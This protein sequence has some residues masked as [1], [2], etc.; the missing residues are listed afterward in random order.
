[1]PPD[2]YPMELMAHAMESADDAILITGPDLDPP[3]PTIEYVNPAFTRMTGYSRDEVVGRTPRILQGPK[4]SRDLLDR[5]RSDLATSGQFFGQTINYRK[6]G[7]EY[8]AEWK[9]SALMNSE[10]RVE[11]W[12]AIQRD[13][14]GRRP[15]DA[16]R[17]L[18]ASIVQWSDDAIVGKDLNGIVTSWN[19]AAEGIF[20]YTAGEMI[21]K[22]IT[23]LIPE[24]R[25]TEEDRILAKLRRG[26]R[27]EPFETVRIRK[28]G[29]AI[30]V[31]VTISPIRDDTGH[32]VGASKIVRDITRSKQLEREREL[33]LAREMELRVEAERANQLK[34]EFL[35]TLSHEL[36]TPLTAILGWAQLLKT[37]KVSPDEVSRAAEVIYRNTRM[38]SQLVDDLLDMNKILMGKLVLD[39]RIV[40]VQT[41]IEAAIESVAPSAEARNIRISTALCEEAG[42]VWADPTRLQQILWNLLSNSVKFTEPGGNVEISVE[43]TSDHLS[44]R[45]KDDGIG[46]APEFLA[47]VFDRFIQA[48]SSTTRRHGGLGLGL[49]IVKHLVEAQGG[50]VCALSEGKG[51][52]SQFIVKFSRPTALNPVST[53][54]PAAKSA[55][56]AL[57]QGAHMLVVDDDTDTAD[58]IRKIFEQHG[59]TVR[60]AYSAAA[61]LQENLAAYDILVGDI[62]MPDQDGYFLIREIRLLPPRSGGE[63]PAIALTAFNQPEDRRNAIRAGFDEFLAKPVDP[64]TLVSTIA[65]CLRLHRFRN[66]VLPARAGLK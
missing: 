62:G 64:E 30:E 36:R 51:R 60:T 6:D 58:L 65:K 17:E 49:A 46:I 13:V 3:G 47:N 19:P 5:L 57:L 12:V 27:V 24:D 18:L 42:F 31:S 33:L 28:D 8:S 52:G 45:V 63:I 32:V 15:F 2:L 14:T 10:N 48:D 61:A 50:T 34:S 43:Q 53:G 4:T 26:E 21:G 16:A 9:I 23:L 55:G 25:R 54:Q 44:I 41:V 22:S 39:M 7:S 37:G 40:P 11:K 1:M 59:A 66:D 38:Q 20:L 35:A 29:H 56:N